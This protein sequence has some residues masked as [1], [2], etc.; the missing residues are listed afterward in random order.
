MNYLSQSKETL[1]PKEGKIPITPTSQ[2][3]SSFSLVSTTFLMPCRQI[4]KESV[5]KFFLF[6]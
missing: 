2:H 1:L 5:F 4:R 3:A 6:F